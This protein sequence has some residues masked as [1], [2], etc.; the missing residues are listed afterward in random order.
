MDAFGRFHATAVAEI[1]ADRAPSDRDA[2][3]LIVRPYG[4]GRHK[5]PRSRA[6]PARS[7]PRPTNPALTSTGSDFVIVV[8][9]RPRNTFSSSPA[10]SAG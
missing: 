6:A 10:L 5:R 4:S 8:V 3:P 7:V 2:P 1:E 9:G